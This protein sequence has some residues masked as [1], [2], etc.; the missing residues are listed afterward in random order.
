[1]TLGFVSKRSTVGSGMLERT[2]GL[3]KSR[4]LLTMRA[5][6]VSQ[7]RWVGVPSIM[8]CS[9]MK[10]A[11]PL[12]LMM[13][14]KGLSYH[15]LAPS[16]CQYWRARSLRVTG[17]AASRQ[18]TNEAASTCLTAAALLRE[19]ARRFLRAT[20]PWS[21]GREVKLPTGGEVCAAL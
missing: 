15:L 14:C 11:V 19:A 4:R 2:E 7:R 6:T 16:P 1:M 3:S 18:T 20:A 9:P 13:N 8:E 17:E 5:L 12:S 10:P 21:R